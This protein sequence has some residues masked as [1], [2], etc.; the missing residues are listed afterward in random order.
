M[1][2]EA[3]PEVPRKKNHGGRPPGP[4][5]E[6][7]L[8][9]NKALEERLAKLEAAVA[10]K[11]EAMSQSDVAQLAAAIKELT[12]LHPKA[13]QPISMPSGPKPKFVPYKG[14]VRAKVDCAIGTFRRGPDPSKGIAA[15]VFAVDV[16][17]LW[18]DDPFEPVRQI[19]TNDAEP[20]YAVRDD[21]PVIDYRWR[22]RADSASL[23]AESRA[24]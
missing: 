7:L 15:E 6:T 11:P 19:D 17:V 13:A 12:D 1:T 14:L 8:A 9:Q 22:P 18:S 5:R 16:P 10:A 4:S 20:R 24:V 3:V 2:D 23:F 21:V